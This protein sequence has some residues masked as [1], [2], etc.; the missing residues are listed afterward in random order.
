MGRKKIIPCHG[1]WPWLFL[2]FLLPEGIA[3]VLLH[4]HYYNQS[5]IIIIIN[6]LSYS[7]HVF[8][9]QLVLLLIN[10]FFIFSDLFRP[11]F[12]TVLLVFYMCMCP[13]FDTTMIF[14]FSLFRSLQWLW[15]GPISHRSTIP[16][17]C[18]HSCKK[19]CST[20]SRNHSW[21]FDYFILLFIV[22]CGVSGR[23]H[24]SVSIVVDILKIIYI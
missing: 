8:E 16:T 14:G 11:Y 22:S 1:P 20:S 3:E 5:I 12:R 23:L 19:N 6:Q 4:L 15:N 17:F 13:L 2:S 21:P 18:F 9:K 7:S 24:C 10:F